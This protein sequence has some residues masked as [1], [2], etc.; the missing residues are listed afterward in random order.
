MKSLDKLRESV[1]CNA[2]NYQGPDIHRE[3]IDLAD[4][5]QAEVDKFYLPRPLFEDGE[6]VQFDDCVVLNDEGVSMCVMGIEYRLDDGSMTLIGDSGWHIKLQD[7][8]KLKRPPEPDTQ[9]KIDADASMNPIAYCVKH[10]IPTNDDMDDAELHEIKTMHL[11][12]R[13][14]KVC[15]AK[16]VEVSK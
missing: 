4:K 1:L 13:Q 14:R 6:P 10:G 12:E 7:G 11:L 5:I 9:E 15:E 2:R 16:N 3:A 8:V